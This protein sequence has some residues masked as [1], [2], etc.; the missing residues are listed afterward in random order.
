M[1]SDSEDEDE[2]VLNNKTAA[3]I[4]ASLQPKKKLPRRSNWKWPF[5][6]KNFQNPTIILPNSRIWP[7]ILNNYRFVPF[8]TIITKNATTESN[9]KS[10]K[11]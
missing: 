9:N 11:S 6:E 5:M 2:L 3:L 8:L 10:K 4:A 7:F 1:A